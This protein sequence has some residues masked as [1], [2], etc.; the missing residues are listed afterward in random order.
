MRVASEAVVCRTP[1]ITLL[2]SPNC[3][4]TPDDPPAWG[5]FISCPFQFV[6]EIISA[7][8]SRHGAE[9]RFDL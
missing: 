8:V 6:P 7:P 2:P 4:P 3:R 1:E 9:R 5:K